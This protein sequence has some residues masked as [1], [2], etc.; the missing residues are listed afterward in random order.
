MANIYLTDSDEEA[1]VD[2]VKDQKQLYDKTNDH[3][4][5][6]VCFWERLTS[7]RNMC[8]KVCMKTWF[9]LQKTHYSKL[10]QSKSHNPSLIKPQRNVLGEVRQ[11][12]QDVCQECKRWF[13]LQKTHNGK[14]KQSK[15]DQ[16][17]KDYGKVETGFRIN[18]TS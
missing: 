16:A 13:E 10:T 18:I 2:F 9:E 14:L 12:L 15:S 6:K 3:F 7:S 5:D 17:P 8:V 1:I 4:K 11:Q